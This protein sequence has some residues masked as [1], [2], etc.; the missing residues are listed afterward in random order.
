MNEELKQKIAKTLIFLAKQVLVSE[1]SPE[2]IKD[3]PDTPIVSSDK[4]ETPD[5]KKDASV[6]LVAV[7]LK[8][9]PP[10]VQQKIR[11]L[12]A[13]EQELKTVK[14]Q[15]DAAAAALR[16]RASELEKKSKQLDAE[17]APIIEE[18]EGQVVR[19]RKLVL[20]FDPKKSQTPRY[21]DAFVEALTKVDDSTAQALRDFAEGTKGIVRF[22]DLRSAS[23]NKMAGIFD[24]ITSFFAG[25]AGFL[26]L[27]KKHESTITDAVDELE[28][29][30]KGR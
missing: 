15:I 18:V 22:L 21:K 16:R 11:N 10:D 5:D 25:L 14:A 20:A 19:A 1:E 26:G 17:L 29:A 6:E 8:E 4:E 2:S 27:S 23:V 9:L 30:V 3:S 24:A 13:T 28:S 12:V 7:Q